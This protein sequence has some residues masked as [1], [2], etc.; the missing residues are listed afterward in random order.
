VTLV[1]ELDEEFA[2]R[3]LS[4]KLNVNIRARM[5]GLVGKPEVI[6]WNRL[7]VAGLAAAATPAAIEKLRE[8]RTQ[9]DDSFRE[10][11]TRNLVEARKK[12]AG[13]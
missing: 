4:E 3:V 13:E 11:V 12:A 9:G 2:T 6:E 5:G 10:F 7:A 1:A 8:V